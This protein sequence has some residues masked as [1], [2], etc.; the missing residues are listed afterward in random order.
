MQKIIEV[1]FYKMKRQ[2]IATKPNPVI[3][4]YY[5]PDFARGFVQDII[6]Q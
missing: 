5:N 1:L 2:V 4:N 3:R 6:K